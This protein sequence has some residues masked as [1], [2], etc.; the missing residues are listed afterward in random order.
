LEIGE[1]NR[2]TKQDKKND[3]EKIA[4]GP[5]ATKNLQIFLA[6]TQSEAG[7]KAPDSNRETEPVGESGK[8]K[9]PGQAEEKE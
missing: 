7:Q 4:Q 6:I 1:R 9:S 3:Q 8:E 5:N 2:G